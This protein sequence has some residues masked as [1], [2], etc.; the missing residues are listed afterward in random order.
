[1]EVVRPDRINDVLTS[2]ID[3]EDDASQYSPSCVGPPTMRAPTLVSAVLSWL[4]VAAGANTTRNVR[5][6]MTTAG[7]AGLAS[8]SQRAP[9]DSPQADRIIKAVAVNASTGQVLAN[10][11]LD[12]LFMGRIT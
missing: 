10:R 8:A 2:S 1:M 11:R 12:A 6:S 7:H 9:Q 4:S 5:A 3:A